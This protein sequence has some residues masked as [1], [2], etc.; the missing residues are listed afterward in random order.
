[1]IPLVMLVGSLVV[2]FVQHKRGRPTIC[3]TTRKRIPAT[4]FVGLWAGFNAWFV[5]HWLGPRVRARGW[6][7]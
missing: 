2:N 1:M 6:W 3:S 7:W 4:V 5:G